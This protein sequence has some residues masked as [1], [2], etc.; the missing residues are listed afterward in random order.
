MNPKSIDFNI[1]IYIYI[2]YDIYIN[3]TQT[4]YDIF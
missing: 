4:T 3:D 2:Y 1:Y